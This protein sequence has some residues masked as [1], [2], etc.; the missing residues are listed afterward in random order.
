MN[1]DVH[2]FFHEDTS[3]V[4]YLVL[5]PR[6]HAA[7]VIDP[8]L[9]FDPGSGRLKRTSVSALLDRADAL[10]A[11]IQWILETHVHAD[12]LSGVQAVKARTDAPVVIG[13]RV[14]AVQDVFAPRFLANDVR[15]DLFDRLV[16]DGDELP[17]G[18]LTIKVMDTP[19]HTGACVSYL[20]GDA[21]FT[22][23]TL[24]M[25]DYGT[26]RTDF[27][28]GDAAT[29][30]RTIRK[31]LSLPP[32]TR[33]FVGHDYKTPGRETF[34]WETTVA[35]QRAHNV[36]INETIDEASFVAARKARD[37]ALAPP[38]LLLPALQVNIRAGRLPP[39][40]GDGV[41]RLRI[42]VTDRG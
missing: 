38:R 25:P 26:A 7:A 11:K 30:Y 36:A 2:A 37:D 13:A 17:L 29:L 33:I 19:G 39:P 12:H 3:S 14:G 1:P 20:V 10:G 41:I 15:P 24:F 35:E 34:A 18:A 28:G 9:D 40:D 23:D 31:I 5:D 4:S 8:V 32:Q 21:A 42:P 6:T 22:G 27:P 16:A